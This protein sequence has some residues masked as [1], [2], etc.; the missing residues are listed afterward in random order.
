MKDHRTSGTGEPG[1]AP[2]E[3]GTNP[4]HRILVVDDDSSIRQLNT[5]VLLDSG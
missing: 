2:A 5:E 4:S 1:K 3:W